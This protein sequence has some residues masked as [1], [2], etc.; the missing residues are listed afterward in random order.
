MQAHGALDHA[1]KKK[2]CANFR[3]TAA[4]EHLQALTPWLNKV[5]WDNIL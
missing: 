1:E 3:Y 4:Y 2:Q 5:G